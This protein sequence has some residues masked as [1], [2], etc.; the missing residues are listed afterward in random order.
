MQSQVTKNILNTII[1]YDILDYPLT[2]FEIWKYLIVATGDAKED[3]RCSLEEISREINSGKL[4]NHISESLGFYF[5]KG[6]EELVSQRLEHNKH[7]ISKYKIAQ[8]AA[9]WLRFCPFVRMIALTGS[10]AMK[11]TERNSDIDYFVVLEQGRIWTGRL[12]ATA[13][14]HL[15]GMRRHGSKVKDRICLNYFIKSDNLEIKLKDIFGA[16]EYSF[17]FPIF[18]YSYLGAKSDE[19]SRAAFERFSEKNIN[20]IKKIKP[21]FGFAELESPKYLPHSRLS[22]FIQKWL[23]YLI[24]ALGG[25]IMESWVRK[26]QVRKIEKNP[27]THKRGAY[28]EYDDK[29]LIFLPEPQGEKIFIEYMKRLKALT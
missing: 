28:V 24:N 23:E 7:S 25:D 27:L 10:V 9:K 8:K 14:V 16:N 26:F 21:N 20:W 3:S 29:N 2:S 19:D 12:L 17:I 13:L 4:V 5:L 22:K 1:F 18:A 6:R 11:N 15:L